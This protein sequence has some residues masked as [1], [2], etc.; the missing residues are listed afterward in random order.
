MTYGQVIEKR[1]EQNKAL[2]IARTMLDKLHLGV[3][4]VEKATGLTKQ[5]LD[6]LVRESGLN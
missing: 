4:V 5:E 1:G 2:A 3:D 6:K